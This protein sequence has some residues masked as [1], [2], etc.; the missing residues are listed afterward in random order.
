MNKLFLLFLLNLLILPVYGVPTSMHR[1]DWAK[2]IS[3]RSHPSSQAKE[4]LAK[5]VFPSFKSYPWDFF[6]QQN[7]QL[8]QQAQSRRDQEIRETHFIYDNDCT[9]F[10]KMIGEMHWGRFRP[11]YMQ[12]IQKTKYIYLSDASSHGTQTI[13]AEVSRILQAA[14]QVN[15]NARIL[16]ATE[17]AARTQSDQI[18]LHIAGEK[19]LP[20]RIVG[21]N[22]QQLLLE[23]DRLNI[24]ILGLDDELLSESMPVKDN[25]TA[26]PHNYDQ[27]KIKLGDTYVFAPLSSQ[28]VQQ[29]LTKYDDHALEYVKAIQNYQ[30]EKET[31]QTLQENPQSMAQELGMSVA[32]IKDFISLYENSLED[33]KEQVEKIQRFFHYILRDFLYRS[34]WGVAKRNEQWTRYIQALTPFYD[35]IV[36]YAGNAHLDNNVYQETSVLPKIIHRPYVLLN[37]YTAEQLSEFDQNFY[38]KCEQIQEEEQASVVINEGPLRSD[39]EQSIAEKAHLNAENELIPPPGANTEGFFFIRQSYNPDLSEDEII[40]LGQFNPKRGAPGDEWDVP[41]VQF[42]VFLQQNTNNND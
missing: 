15:P 7:S 13:P 4:A 29:V 42:D 14:R 20:F 3:E 21:P 39:V 36:V 6:L 17:F 2:Y 32:Q 41:C 27:I 8:Q 31:L 24:D 18:P 22:Y 37:F 40:T 23:C 10:N 30:G 33:G 26:Q 25:K 28:K 11:D 35:I 9:L 19:D 12:A 1:Q 16:L 34:T 38:A 5:Q